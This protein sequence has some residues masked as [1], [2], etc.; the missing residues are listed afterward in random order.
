MGDSGRPRED[1]EPRSCWT[2]SFGEPVNHEPKGHGG[3]HVPDG[4]EL[5][6]DGSTTEVGALGVPWIVAHVDECVVAAVVLVGTI[7]GSGFLASQ[8]E[9]VKAALLMVVGGGLGASFIRVARTG[10]FV[11]IHGVVVRRLWRTHSLMWG[12]IERF[13][14]LPGPGVIRGKWDVLTVVPQSSRPGNV[15]VIRIRRPNQGRSG[16]LLAGDVTKE[17]WASVDRAADAL[18][19][20][21][22]RFTSHQRGDR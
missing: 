3:W 1:G 12:E 21:R 16:A 10:L 2:S 20:L 7:G 15:P 11:G 8:G 9:L 19:D 6:A 17:A 18:N 13:A 22:S 5:S 14:V 4:S